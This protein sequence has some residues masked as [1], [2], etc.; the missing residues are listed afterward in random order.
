VKMC[1]LALRRATKVAVYDRLNACQHANGELRESSQAKI[2]S[3]QLEILF[4]TIHSAPQLLNGDPSR[5]PQARN[6]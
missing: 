4:T 5:K 3:R 2:L 6:K 1:S